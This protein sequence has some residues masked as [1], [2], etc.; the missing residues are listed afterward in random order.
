MKN[1]CQPDCPRRKAGCQIGCEEREEWVIFHNAEMEARQKKK[2]RNRILN[3][4]RNGTT[5]RKEYLRGKK[6]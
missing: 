4:Y 6:K 5:A 3:E 2:D 1:P